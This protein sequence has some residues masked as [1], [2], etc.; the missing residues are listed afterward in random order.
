MLPGLSGTRTRRT[1]RMS[2]SRHASSEPGAA[3]R[4][5]GEVAHVQA[6]LDGDLAQGVGL[7]PR[8]DLEDADRALLEAQA[9]LA[10]ELGD[11]VAGR[12]DVERDLAAEQVRRDPAEQ[13]VRVGDRRLGA[14]LAVAQRARVGASRLRADLERALRADPGD[15]P[16]AGADGDHVDHRDLAGVGADAA[17]GGQRRCAVDDDG[18]VG[19]RAAAVERDHAGEAGPLGDHRRAEGA[20]RRARTARW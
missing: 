7:V 4:H 12:V 18:D 10:G 2:A 15:R 6:A 11:T 5:H 3:E 14:A 13:H 20:G 1:P 9:Q 8:R 19:R 17:L 16:A